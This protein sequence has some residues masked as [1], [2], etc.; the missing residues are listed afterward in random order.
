MNG[1]VSTRSRVLPHLTDHRAL[2]PGTHTFEAFAKGGDAALEP[3]RD[4]CKFDDR[5]SSTV[6][7]KSLETGARDPHIVNYWVDR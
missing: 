6:G 2:L 1:S 7:N 5:A 4:F 3:H